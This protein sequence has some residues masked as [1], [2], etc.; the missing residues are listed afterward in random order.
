MVS[1]L[2]VV[3]SID[4]VVILTFSMPLVR[5][6][7]VPLLVVFVQVKSGVGTPR[8]EQLRITGLGATSA[9]STGSTVI[10]AATVCAGEMVK[11]SN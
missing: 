7:D 5:T 8:V 6:V 1:V 3:S 4:T 10:T 11:R 2:V 9:T